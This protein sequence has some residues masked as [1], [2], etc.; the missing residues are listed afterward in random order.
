V[1]RRMD[2]RYHALRE[3]RGGLWEL[4]DAALEAKNRLLVDRIMVDS[5]DGLATTYLRTVEGLCFHES[6]QM[7]GLLSSSA[8]AADARSLA[9]VPPGATVAPV[10][11]RIA[12]NFRSALEKT[13][14]IIMNEKLLVH[15][16]ECP[17]LVYALRQPIEEL[18]RS[19]VM[20]AL[21]WVISALEETCGNE[22]LQD[23]S[24][25]P[26]YANLSRDRE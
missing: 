4:G 17:R 16:A 20:K 18:L 5:S 14:G 22:P 11:L 6:G 23:D 1:G 9:G 24:A 25:E 15:E 21:V 26:W 10:P 12:T 13:R 8:I 19:P 3:K 7:P 2:G